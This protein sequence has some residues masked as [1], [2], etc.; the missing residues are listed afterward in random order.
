MPET[1][2]LITTANAISLSKAARHVA[3]DGRSPHVSTLWRWAR[4]GVN[5]VRLGYK[6]YGRRIV[7]SKEALD[8]FSSELANA[9]RSPA[10]NRPHKPSRTQSLSDSQ[11]ANAVATAEAEL[12]IG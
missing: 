2:S 6:K 7:T 8:H 4:V 12:A 10:G 3:V 9:D 1:N 5:G 11:H